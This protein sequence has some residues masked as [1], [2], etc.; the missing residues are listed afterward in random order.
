[1]S[2]RPAKLILEPEQEETVREGT[3]SPTMRSKRRTP[4]RMRPDPHTVQ[5]EV[6]EPEFQVM[7]IHLLELVVL[8]IV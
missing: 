3:P 4:K 2:F 1:M 6:L 8:M 7:S 5:E